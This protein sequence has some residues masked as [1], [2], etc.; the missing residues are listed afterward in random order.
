M[1]LFLSIFLVIAVM[2]AIGFAFAAIG[3]VI[4]GA[5][6]SARMFRQ[7]ANIINKNL[8]AS[9]LACVA[10]LSWRF[11]RPGKNVGQLKQ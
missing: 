6:Q 7:G 9:Y 4:G 5:D 3:A 1:A 11:M 10:L 2:V 8:L